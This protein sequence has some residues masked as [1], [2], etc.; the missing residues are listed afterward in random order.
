MKDK[1]CVKEIRNAIT[2]VKQQYALPVYNLD[3]IELIPVNEI[4]FT[5]SDQLLLDVMLMEIRQTI[6]KFAIKKKG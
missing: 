2:R 1:E 3:N 5:I 6:I 4:V